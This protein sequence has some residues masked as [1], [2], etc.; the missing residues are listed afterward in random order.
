LFDIVRDVYSYCGGIR[1][2]GIDVIKNVGISRFILRKKN[3]NL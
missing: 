3:N 1:W 2:R